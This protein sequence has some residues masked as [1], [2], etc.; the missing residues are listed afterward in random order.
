MGEAGMSVIWINSGKLLLYPAYV[1]D[2]LDRVTAA[3][4]AAGDNAG[5][6]LGVTEA[7][8]A[9]MQGLVSIN[10]LGVSANVISQAAS[11]IKAAP[12]LAGARTLPG[13]L[14]PLVG[15]APTAVNFSAAD[16]NRKTGLLGNTTNRY[17]N[18]NRSNSADPQNNRHAAVFANTP[19]NG[20][21]F[22][23]SAKGASTDIGSTGIRARNAS[24]SS[25]VN[26]SDSQDAAGAEMPINTGTFKG[27]S[28][29][30]SSSYTSRVNGSNFTISRVSGTPVSA[31]YVL[32]ARSD[33]VA[34]TFF[35]GRISFYSIGEAL[36]LSLLESR[37][38]TL[39]AA[40]AS[41]IP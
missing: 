22:L 31:N 3:D 21:S 1:Q 37:V 28:R 24:G 15:A 12:I 16:Y 25:C 20:G 33:L 14:V 11:L 41:A 27:V 13:A 6:E 38:A 26:G 7:V 2:Y 30:N 40:L 32:F 19:D 29:N 4:V 10:Y 36:T 8:S 34:A 9:F 17:I 23:L 5:L 18:S 39:M 35:A